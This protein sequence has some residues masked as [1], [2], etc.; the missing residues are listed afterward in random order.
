MFDAEVGGVR[1]GERYDWPN[2]QVLYVPPNSDTVTALFIISQAERDQV[3]RDAAAA[4][5][6][7]ADSKTTPEEVGDIIRQ[8]IEVFSIRPTY[9]SIENT[10][11]RDYTLSLH[12]GAVPAGTTHVEMSIHGVHPTPARLPYSNTVTDYGFD[13]PSTAAANVRGNIRGAARIEAE[14]RFVDRSDPANPN[15]LLRQIFS[16]DVE[17]TTPSDASAVAA[18]LDTERTQ[19]QAADA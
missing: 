15:T 14:I 12:N 18:D 6:S 2:G 5:Q 8:N 19:R 13:F 4:A 1:A 11:A 16:L 9:W 17:E 3:A 7:T 10:D